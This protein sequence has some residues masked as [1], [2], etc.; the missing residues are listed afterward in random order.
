MDE[1]NEYITALLYNVKEIA[2][3]EARSLGKET[4]PEFVLSLTEV[5]ASQIKLL[6]QDL[7]AFARHGRRSV[8]SMEDVKKRHIGK[9][10][11]KVMPYY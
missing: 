1:D 7:E 2:D 9:K 3:R 5:L 6:G 8:I 4:S 11:R 10:L